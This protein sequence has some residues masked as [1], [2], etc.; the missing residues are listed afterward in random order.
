VLGTFAG[1]VDSGGGV[2][3][4]TAEEEVGAGEVNKVVPTVLGLG[5]GT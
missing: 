1:V 2:V 5:R 3:V 4:S